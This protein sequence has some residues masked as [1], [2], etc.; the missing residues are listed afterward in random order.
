MNVLPCVCVSVCCHHTFPP[1]CAVCVAE[2]EGWK[3][4]RDMTNIIEGSLETQDYLVEKFFFKLPCACLAAWEDCMCA[5]FCV[6]RGLRGL[7]FDPFLS[8]LGKLLLMNIRFDP[9]KTVSWNRKEILVTFWFDLF[10]YFRH[11]RANTCCL[12]LTI[13]M[14]PLSQLWSSGSLLETLLVRLRIFLA[15]GVSVCYCIHC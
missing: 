7:L 5:C 14:G 3:E 13:T 10:T 4:W 1:V 2:D 9:R 12:P 8:L 6:C 15:A 11:Q